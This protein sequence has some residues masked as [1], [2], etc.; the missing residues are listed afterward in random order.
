MSKTGSADPDYERWLTKSTFLENNTLSIIVD[1][2]FPPLKLYKGYHIRVRPLILER[3]I[4][5]NLL[6]EV[7]NMNSEPE[8]LFHFVAYIL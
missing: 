5:V 3:K 4:L 7:H 6:R 8:C 2:L 1:Q